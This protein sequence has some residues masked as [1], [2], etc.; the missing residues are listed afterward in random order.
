MSYPKPARRR[1]RRAL[2]ASSL[3]FA[4]VGLSAC[5]S[6]TASD[7]RELDLLIP[8]FPA[9]WDA[10]ATSGFYLTAQLL[11]NE[12]LVALAPDG[13]FVPTL[14]ESVDQPDISTYVYTLREGVSFTD[15]SPLTVD[16]VLYTFDLHSAEG[17]TSFMARYMAGIESV[18]ATGEREITVKL[19]AP[20]PEWPYTVARMGI[21]SAAYYDENPDRVGTP[22]VPQLGTGPYEVAS[23]SA[24][25][26]LDLARNGDYWGEAPVYDAINFEAPAD[27][28]ARLLALQSG[29]YDAILQAPL[30]QLSSLSSVPGYTLTE[31]PE[32][33]TYRI[34]MDVTKAPFDDPAVRRA[35]AH[36][37]DREAMLEAALGG[38][39]S[40]TNGL[41]PV[42]LLIGLGDAQPVE[43][44]YASFGESF[45][46]DVDAAAKELA[47]SSVPDGFAVE[48]LVQQSD[49]AQTLMAQILAQSLGEIGIDVS[50]SQVDDTTFLSRLYLDK[51]GDGLVVFSFNAGSPEPANM[52][53]S[54]FTPGDFGNMEQFTS[55]A[56]TDALQAYKSADDDATR[57][58]LLLQI[59]EDA[60]AEVPYVP[61]FHPSVA[62]IVAD[63]LEVL[64][65]TSFWWASRIDQIIVPAA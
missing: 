13:S 18:E 41:V 25:S 4:L 51:S 32:V 7:G 38:H 58:A 61:V 63:D 23:I 20:D 52:A 40:V 57:Q 26:K 43:E 65:F 60:N 62:A 47:A 14:A 54:A 31:V 53:R 10:R 1:A 59:F 24:G 39:G 6:D 17:T 48:V 29:E 16:D 46:Y 9:S 34:S 12:P 19:A 37:V 55:P 35:I 33:A 64:D 30:S 15:G 49:P 44:A 42:D 50:V 27:D 11:I 21:V 28:N 3:V 45:T 56:I 8:A 22:D 5:A 2:F 36:A